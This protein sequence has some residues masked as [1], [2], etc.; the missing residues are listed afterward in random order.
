M[1]TQRH[2][3]QLNR[4]LRY[5]EG[6]AISLANLAV[7]HRQLGRLKQAEQF[8]RQALALFEGC[9]LLE[10]QVS[11]WNGLG[12]LYFLTNALDESEACYRQAAL[13]E[14]EQTSRV[15]VDL[16]HNLGVV[17]Q[18][19]KDWARAISHFDQALE[20]A[21][22][23]G[24]AIGEV[25]ILINLG[26]TYLMAQSISQALGAQNEAVKLAK[27]YGDPDLLLRALAG[28]GDTLKR[29]G[30]LDAA[31]A[32]YEE[33]IGIVERLRQVLVDESDR[34]SFFGFGNPALYSRIVSLFA[35]QL[36]RPVDAFLYVERSRSRAFV[37]LLSSSLLNISADQASPQ[38]MGSF[39]DVCS[40]LVPS[41]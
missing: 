3:L 10:G 29:V 40:L 39:E 38:G 17:Y 1:E 12:H 26:Y 30:A 2:A 32:D 15:Q 28:R 36:H 22:T 8:Y 13:L 37:D 35:Y 5:T 24:Y 6:I 27:G 41:Q 19:R 25:T 20:M 18:A 33:A 16:L 14:P 21:R 9:Q 31:R 7:L 34:I 23:L 11:C 4:E